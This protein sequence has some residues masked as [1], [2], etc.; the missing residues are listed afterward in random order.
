MAV[1]SIK[2]KHPFASKDEISDNVAFSAH[3]SIGVD[4]HCSIKLSGS[5]PVEPVIPSTEAAAWF[6]QAG[7]EHQT[8]D[9]HNTTIWDLQCSKHTNIN[10]NCIELVLVTHLALSDALYQ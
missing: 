3:C 6:M 1:Q 4:E 2:Q 5:C 7:N 8:A 10:T 9:S